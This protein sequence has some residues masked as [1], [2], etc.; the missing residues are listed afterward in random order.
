MLKT[1]APINIPIN[2]IEIR[3][4]RKPGDGGW[5]KSSVAFKPKTLVLTH[6]EQND[7]ALNPSILF[8]PIGDCSY[9]LELT[10]RG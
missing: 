1:V 6:S 3:V 9:L 7:P 10:R 8:P 2:H 5:I 4:A